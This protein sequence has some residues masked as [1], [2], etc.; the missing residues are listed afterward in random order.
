MRRL[1]FL[2]VCVSCPAFADTG[3]DGSLTFGTDSIQVNIST[4]S[5][6]QIMINDPYVTKS[7]IIN[8]SS[9]T[10]VCVSSYNATLS[11]STTTSPAIPQST[12]FSMDGPTTPWWGGLWAVV[13]N[14][15]AAAQP[16]AQRIS[17][18]RTK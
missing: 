2:L 15:A 11:V 1:L 10:A 17:V 14:A 9:W 12:V 18:I 6:T 7:T 16:Q 5:N 3:A 4:F 8:P 13:C